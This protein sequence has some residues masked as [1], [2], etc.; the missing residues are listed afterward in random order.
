M[1]TQALAES[2][3]SRRRKIQALCSHKGH[4][5]KAPL[6]F[7]LLF[8]TIQLLAFVVRPPTAH[9]ERPLQLVAFPSDQQFQSCSLFDTPPSFEWQSTETFKAA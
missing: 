7:L 3:S 8:L 5:A 2:P 1:N 6:R 9:A 4:E